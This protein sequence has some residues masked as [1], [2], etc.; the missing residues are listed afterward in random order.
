MAIRSVPGIAVSDLIFRLEEFFGYV[1]VEKLGGRGE[2]P[3]HWTC[4]GS[5]KKPDP[6]WIRRKESCQ[7]GKADCVL[8]LERRQLAQ[9]RYGSREVCNGEV[10]FLLSVV[11][12]ERKSCR[13]MRILERNPHGMQDMGRFQGTGCACGT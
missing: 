3:G 6:S 8:V 5:K 10:N 13:A 1:R 11:A 2:E 12:G 4:L 9:C 7:F